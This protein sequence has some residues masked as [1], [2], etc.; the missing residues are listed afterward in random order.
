V[1]IDKR[2]LKESFVPTN[3]VDVRFLGLG[4]RSVQ[5]TA[6]PLSLCGVLSSVLSHV[7][8]SVGFHT[9]LTELSELGRQDTAHS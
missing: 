7:P 4:C 3:V 8:H 6:V 5:D 2:A 9:A 1:Q